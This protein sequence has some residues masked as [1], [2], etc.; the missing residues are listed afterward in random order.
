[1]AIHS[2]LV[3]GVVIQ[4][5]SVGIAGPVSSYEFELVLIVGFVVAFSGRLEGGNE[6]EGRVESPVVVTEADH[7]QVL[8]GD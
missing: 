5:L 8:V 2:V 6:I 7:D 1:M 3:F 4:V